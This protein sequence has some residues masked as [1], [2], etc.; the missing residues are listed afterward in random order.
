[1]SG[2]CAANAAV[3][4]ARLGARARFAGPLGGPAGADSVSDTFLR[5]AA[6]EDIDCSGVRARGGRA[7]PVSAIWSTARGER[8]IVTYRDDR[9]NGARPADPAALVADADAVLADNRFPEFVR[10]VCE[11]A[12]RAAFRSCSTPTGRAATA[13]RCSRSSPT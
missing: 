11:A 8:M 9:L 2:G 13:T 1:M 3:A 5:L 12:R 7:V 10:E 6:N 4:M